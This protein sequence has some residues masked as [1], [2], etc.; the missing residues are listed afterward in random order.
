MICIFVILLIGWCRT[1]MRRARLV[2]NAFLY[3][4]YV[5]R[6]YQ[7]A[8][9]TSIS[10]QFVLLCCAVSSQLR[11]DSVFTH[12]H[13]SSRTAKSSGTNE[14]G[15]VLERPSRNKEQNSKD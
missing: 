9:V 6:R 14:Y 2:S 11:N 12:F 10:F 5:S 3:T 15:T 4:T 1:R 13:S 8:D 7:S